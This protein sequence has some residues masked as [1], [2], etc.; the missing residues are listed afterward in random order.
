MKRIFSILLCIT[1]LGTV[2]LAQGRKEHKEDWREKV[3]AEK[4]AFLSTELDLTVEEAQAFWPVYN[5]M[6]ALRRDRF[7]AMVDAF[8]ALKNAQDGDDTDALLEAY[9]AAKESSDHIDIEMLPKVRK[10]LSAEKAARLFLAEEKFRHEQI[11]RLGAGRG[12]KAE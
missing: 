4:V 6:E 11:Q 2:A 5:E 12:N 9:L 8:K 7:K 1:V 10:V 3:R